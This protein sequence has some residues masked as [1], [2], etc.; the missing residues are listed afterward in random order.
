MRGAKSEGVRASDR[1]TSGGTMSSRPA[2]PVCDGGA[3]WR[4]GSSI[5][6]ARTGSGPE[7]SRPKRRQP[8]LAGLREGGLSEEDSLSEVLAT[9]DVPT[10]NVGVAKW[11]RRGSA[12]PVALRAARVQIPPPT[13]TA[14]IIFL[15]SN[16][17]SHLN[18]LKFSVIIFDAE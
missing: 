12:K 18:S 4:D 11:L 3:V 16:H 9:E 5:L 14:I 2:G 10:P 8:A 15:P 6:T 17:Y 13:L 7:G 1:E